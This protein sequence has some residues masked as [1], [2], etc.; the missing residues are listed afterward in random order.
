MSATSRTAN[1]IDAIAAHRRVLAAEQALTAAEAAL[2]A[3]LA[4]SDQT[5]EDFA[6]YLLDL[7]S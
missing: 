3:I 5:A 2:D 7:D 1:L 6:D 4:A